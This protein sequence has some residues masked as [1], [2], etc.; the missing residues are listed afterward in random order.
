MGNEK[1]RERNQIRTTGYPNNPKSASTKQKCENSKLFAFKY[2]ALFR[3]YS[4]SALCYV[5]QSKKKT[6]IS[7]K[8]GRK[9]TST[10]E[11]ADAAGQTLR[12]ATQ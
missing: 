4:C 10:E 8:E 11:E 1:D 2:H 12:Q 7:R 6:K 5:R 9:G 3:Y